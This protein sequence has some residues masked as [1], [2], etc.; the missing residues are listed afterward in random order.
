[1][2]LRLYDYWRSS[3]AYRVRIA[4]GLAGRPFD[5]VKVD[6]VAGEH[7]SDDFRSINPLAA[8]PALEI[9]G[10]VFTQSLAIIEYLH[11][12]HPDAGLMPA[13]ALAQYRVRQLSYAVAMDIH[14]IC[15]LRVANHAAE[16]AGGGDKVKRAWMNRFIREG[17]V[18]L[19]GLLQEDDGAVFCFGDRPTMADCCLVP[20]LYNADRWGTRYDDLARISAVA[21][22]CKP[23]S[24]FADAYPDVAA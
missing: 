11:S 14:P 7:N 9:D 15:I 17:L 13:D 24:A 16:I 1:M 3:A 5:R 2:T 20:Q 19:E 22:R 18:A 8:V 12:L 10:K 6:L 23:L 4:L 21:E